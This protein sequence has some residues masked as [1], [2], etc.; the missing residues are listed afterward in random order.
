MNDIILYAQ[1]G[2]SIKEISMLLEI[3]QDQVKEVIMQNDL[4]WWS[5]KYYFA[6][7]QNIFYEINL[8]KWRSTNDL[9]K[10][11]KIKEKAGVKTIRDLQFKATG[12]PVSY[13]TLR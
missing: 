6:Q 5:A 4:L 1:K 2:L 13:K 7:V 3:P 9:H 8:K 12:Y 10:I 11:N